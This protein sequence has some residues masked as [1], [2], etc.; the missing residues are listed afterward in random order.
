MTVTFKLIVIVI[1]I[2][3]DSVTLILFNGIVPLNF[4]LCLIVFSLCSLTLTLCGFFGA[5][6]A[7]HVLPDRWRC[8]GKMTLN[9]DDTN[10]RSWIAMAIGCKLS[11]THSHYDSDDDLH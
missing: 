4:R 2:D 1:R 9:V 5:V 6:D 3:R 11:L 10:D 8:T 7:G